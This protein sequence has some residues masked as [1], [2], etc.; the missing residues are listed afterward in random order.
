[1]KLFKKWR[2][3]KSRIIGKYYETLNDLPIHNWYQISK[4]GDLKYI[5]ISGLYSRLEAFEIYEKLKQDY[6]DLFGVDGDSV[7]IMA[8]LKNLIRLKSQ[9]LTTGQKHLLNFIEMSQG[10][11]DS[12]INGDESTSQTLEAV[13]VGMSQFMGYR[14]DGK[15]TSVVEFREIINLAERQNEKYKNGNKSNQGE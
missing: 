12:L 5:H 2:K 13:L 9:Y 11:L 14:I 6:L 3:P 8:L 4:T 10:E 1:M 15:T 7:M